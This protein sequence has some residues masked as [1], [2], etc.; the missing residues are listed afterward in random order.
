MSQC[1]IL[2]HSP[3]P[4]TTSSSLVNTHYFLFP[5][6]CMIGGLQGTFPEPMSEAGNSI[7]CT[8]DTE[9]LTTIFNKTASPVRPISFP[10]RKCSRA[11]SRCDQCINQEQCQLLGQYTHTSSE[12]L[13]ITVNQKEIRNSQQLRLKDCIIPSWNSK[14]VGE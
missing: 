11:Q 2:S 6:L 5:D 1:V 8:R 9:L 4:T 13:F 14:T 7:V 10:P 12:L 3:T